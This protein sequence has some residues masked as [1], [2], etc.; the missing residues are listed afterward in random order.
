MDDNQGLCLQRPYVV[1]ST[2]M[3]SAKCYTKFTKTHMGDLKTTKLRS[4]LK[5]NECSECTSACTP[6]WQIHTIQRILVI[7]K[8]RIL[9]MT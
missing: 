3:V 7:S 6:T 5:N 4:T 8:I 2:L 9:A 1:E